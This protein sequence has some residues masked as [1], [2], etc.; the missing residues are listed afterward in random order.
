MLVR[1]D[2]RAGFNMFRV[3]SQCFNYGW[4]KLH[5]SLPVKQALESGQIYGL[6][7]KAG[8]GGGL[9]LRAAVVG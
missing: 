8:R 2:S 5:S 7:E 3:V 6:E 9:Q 1:L 4:L